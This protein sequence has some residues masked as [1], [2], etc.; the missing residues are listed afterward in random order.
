MPIYEYACAKCEREFE[1]EQ[2]ITD[3]GL[4]LFVIPLG[5]ELQAAGHS[6]GRFD[7]TCAPGVLAELDEQLTDMLLYCVA[8]HL[9]RSRGESPTATRWYLR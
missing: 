9:L 5:K 3:D 2:R 4:G 1:V 7:Q 8:V 6:L